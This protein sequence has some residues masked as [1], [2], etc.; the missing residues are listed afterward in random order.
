[1]HVSQLEAPQRADGRRELLAIVLAAH[2]VVCAVGGQAQPDAA[3][4]P[5][6]GDGTD[7]LEAEP[8]ALLDAAAG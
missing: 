7:N 8:V 3:R 5:L 1:M 6:R 2:V 4:R